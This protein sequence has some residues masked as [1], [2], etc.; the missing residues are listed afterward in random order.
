MSVSS[1][2]RPAGEGL[3]ASKTF[4][5]G[6]ASLYMLRINDPA[7]KVVAMNGDGHPVLVHK[8][9]GSGTLVY[10]IDTPYG[11][12][13]NDPGDYAEFKQIVQN[14]LRLGCAD[15]ALREPAAGRCPRVA[16]CRWTWGS[17]PSTSK[18]GTTPASVRISSND[19][20]QAPC[21]RAR[22]PPCGRGAENGR[23]SASLEFGSVFMAVRWRRLCWSRIAGSRRSAS[24]A[25]R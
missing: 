15:L 9:I 10:F 1:I 17:S 2:E 13:W 6:S 25:C 23:L 12:F 5:N 3:P 14:A 8:S 24:R 16:R 22:A 21:G 18:K 19:P 7:A 11:G 20:D 4:A